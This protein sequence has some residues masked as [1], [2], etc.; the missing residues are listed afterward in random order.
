MK[1]LIIA[2]GFILTYSVSFSQD[3]LENKLLEVYSVEQTESILSDSQKKKYYNTVVFKSFQIN[4]ISKEKAKNL[5]YKT[6]NTLELK[7]LDGSIT[8][9]SPEKIVESFVDGTFNILRLNIERDLKD[10]RTYFLG[11]TNYYI[12]ISSLQAISQLQKQ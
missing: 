11:N 4:K 1:N 2:L 6:L 7:N 3:A 5:K 12:R 9:I 8:S 10:S